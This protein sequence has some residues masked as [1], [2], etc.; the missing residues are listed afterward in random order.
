MLK[1]LG[2]HDR[3]GDD[4]SRERA[5]ACF[6]DARDGRDTKGAEFAFMPKTAATVHAGKIPKR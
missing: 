4:R 3:R 6:V 5:P 1:L 2:Q